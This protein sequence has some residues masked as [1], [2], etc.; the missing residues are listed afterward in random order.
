MKATLTFILPEQQ[1]EFENCAKGIDW[2]LFAIE[3][4]NKIRSKLKYE[5]T[6]AE[7]RAA[8]EQVRDWIIAGMDDRALRLYPNYIFNN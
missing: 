8:L 4:D 3:L 6:T 7:Q 1:V 5:E 2:L